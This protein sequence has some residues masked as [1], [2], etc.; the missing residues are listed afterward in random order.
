[1]SGRVGDRCEGFARDADDDGCASLCAA[2]QDRRGIAR[3]AIREVQAGIVFNPGDHTRSDTNHR[4]SDSGV[5]GEFETRAC[6]R[7]VAGNINR[8]HSQGIRPLSRCKCRGPSPTIEAE[9]DSGT[10]LG[11]SAWGDRKGALGGGGV[12]N[13]VRCRADAGSAVDLQ[14]DRRL[15]WFDVVKRKAEFVGLWGDESNALAVWVLDANRHSVRTRNSFEI[16]QAVRPSLPS[17]DTEL[18]VRDGH[19][20]S[21]RVDQCQLIIVSDVVGGY[22]RIHLKTQRQAGELTIELFLSDAAQAGGAGDCRIFCGEIGR[23][24][25]DHRNAIKNAGQGLVIAQIDCRTARLERTG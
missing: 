9:F 5:Q 6:I 11:A 12:C 14:R 15:P 20:R 22:P 17:V 19:T 21:G 3:H 25:N 13:T 10:R 23:L 8:P 24:S 7:D 16:L 18:E 4:H 2:S 1:M